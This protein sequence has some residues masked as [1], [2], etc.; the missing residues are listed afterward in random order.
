M[1]DPRFFSPSHS[2]AIPLPASAAAVLRPD[3]PKLQELA[4]RYAELD[5]PV[6]DLSTWREENVDNE[7]N[8]TWFR[9]DNAYL[10]QYRQLR[11]SAEKKIRAIA[12]YV[13]RTDRLGALDRLTEDGLF[14][15]W[16]FRTEDGQLL[17]R[18]L[19]DSVNEVNAIGRL[20]RRDDLSGTRILDI[21]A[22]Y[23]RLAHRL[24]EFAPEVGHIHCV[25]AVALSTFL[26]DFYLTFRKAPQTVRSVPL[27]EVP[28]LL[29]HNEYDLAVNVHSFSECTAAACAWWL[30]A[31]HG[32]GV[33]LLLVVPNHA[34]RFVSAEKDGSE[35]DLV[36]TFQAHGYRLT[37]K[38][39]VYE[40][41]NVRKAVE[42][43]DSFL[44]FSKT[45]R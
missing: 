1:T 27:D 38:S 24:S 9:G 40:D 44:V 29:Q 31:I 26:C 10:W 14:G 20:L 3:N 42:I 37:E 5:W 4:R 30:D 13:R 43:E 19:L 45:Q 11:S 16:T 35:I 39:F 36:A 8:L 12:S 23:G 28:T 32:A 22:G 18:D 41:P 15:V 34:S 21:G 6:R 25:D 33:P 17:S 2:S 7:V